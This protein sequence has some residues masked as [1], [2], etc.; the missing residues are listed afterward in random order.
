[1]L[2]SF[3]WYQAAGSG[4][5]V[6]NPRKTAGGGGRGCESGY[7]LWRLTS[8]KKVLAYVQDHGTAVLQAFCAK[9]QR[10]IPEYLE[11]AAEWSS[12]RAKAAF[13][14]KSDWE[15]LCGAADTCC[16]QGASC[17]HAAAARSFF[18]AHRA[19]F[20]ARRLAVSLRAIIVSGP[21]KDNKVPFLIGSTNTGK[22]TLVES[23]DDLYGE[24]AVFHLPAETDDK[25]GALRGWLHDK[26][27]VF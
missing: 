20:T 12:A 22:S 18:I 16:P 13:E 4:G 1:M 5:W 27:F 9:R 8:K 24:D 15:V 25:G 19:S 7:A 14:A 11:D 6:G 17:Q 10:K 23:V 2:P 26:R 21:S 3:F